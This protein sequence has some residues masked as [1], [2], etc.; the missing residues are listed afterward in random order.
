M[1]GWDGCGILREG[2][3]SGVRLRELALILMNNNDV[4]NSKLLAVIE[5]DDNA[6]FGAS[7]NGRLA[8]I[9]RSTALAAMNKKGASATHLFRLLRIEV[10]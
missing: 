2:W 9:S 6:S 4:S 10:E 8:E 7:T 1:K 3:G 5:I